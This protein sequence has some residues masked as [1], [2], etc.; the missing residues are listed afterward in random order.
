MLRC[1]P[2]SNHGGHTMKMLAAASVLLFVSASAH[3]QAPAETQT[4]TPAQT[5]KPCEE[6]NDEITKTLAAKG[7]KR[8]TLD[9]VAKDTDAECKSAGTCH[10]DTKNSV[11]NR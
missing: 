10:A 8:Y 2:A 9:V 3:A 1:D 6:L 11:Y 5:A 7:V 4:Q